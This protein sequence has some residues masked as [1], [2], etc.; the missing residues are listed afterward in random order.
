MVH[1]G[2]CCGGGG[3]GD[4]G[5]PD[6]SVTRDLVQGR[7][8]GGPGSG[9]LLRR[10]RTRRWGGQVEPGRPGLLFSD[11]GLVRYRRRGMRRGGRWGSGQ[12]NADVFTRY[13]PNLGACGGCESLCDGV[14][15][16]RTWLDGRGLG[17]GRPAGI[18]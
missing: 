4:A 9:L 17:G 6:I 5:L 14:G 2:S 1:A 3:G 13:S 8:D 18:S 11:L 7:F 15:G 16:G 10:G 12:R